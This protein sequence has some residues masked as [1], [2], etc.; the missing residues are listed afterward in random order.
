[1]RSL[2]KYIFC[3]VIY[4][5]GIL[6]LYR[7]I[8]RNRAAL[9]LMY[10]RVPSR[11][12]MR[13]SLSQSGMIVSDETFRYQVEYL[14]KAYRTI[15]LAELADRLVSDNID[16]SYCAITFDDGWRDNYTGAYPALK[17]LGIPATVFLSTGLI[18][19]DRLFWPERLTRALLES[20]GNRREFLTGFADIER[21]II[22]QV[23]RILDESERHA[24]LVL[25][26]GL[27]EDMKDIDSQAR[28]KFIEAL[29]NALDQS[30]SR[31]RFSRQALNWDEVREMRDH[32]ISFGGH[33]VNH[34]ILTNVPPDIARSEI[35][36]SREALRNNLD[37]EITLFAYPNGNWND[38]VKSMV[39]QAGYRIAVLAENA[40][41]DS[42]TDPLLIGRLNVHEG[43]SAGPNGKFSKAV[44][45]CE[46]N[47][48]TSALRKILT[49][50]REA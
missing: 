49:G 20:T 3:F 23:L 38:E 8:F 27:I 26:D 21:R 17:Q 44:F 15:P 2:F 1:M 36:E 5:S 42:S 41:N 10:H 24:R 50:Q 6:F 29:E 40:L 12:E 43:T 14:S 25:I 46:I 28:E 35:R 19:T 37:E 7:L 4:Y 18:G 22:D 11:S 32:G 30:T 9:V 33:T 47:G 13:N 31:E 16:R 45:A 48:V 34:V 39:E